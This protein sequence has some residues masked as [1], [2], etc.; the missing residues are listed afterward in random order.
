MLK[1]VL[2]VVFLCCTGA[3][4]IAWF[5]RTPSRAA[6]SDQAEHTKQI[7]ALM[8]Q[9]CDTLKQRLDYITALATVDPSH[10]HDRILANDEFLQAKL[11]LAT[12][13]EEEIAIAKD[14][15]K[16]LRERE[17]LIVARLKTGIGAPD[18]E[19]AA[20]AA[21]QQAEIDLLREQRGSDPRP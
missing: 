1:R 16:N 3:L 4:S 15:V 9:R 10:F 13:R 5:A 14:R 11:A 7:T 19:L 8:E 2:C 18:I 12:S 6:D 17:D 20:R 21:R